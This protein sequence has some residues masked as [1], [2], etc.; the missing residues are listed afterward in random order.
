M[1]DDRGRQSE[2]GEGG[3]RKCGQVEERT[4][5]LLIMKTGGS[6]LLRMHKKQFTLYL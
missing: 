2:V 4:G 3:E 1:R 5:E 6:S